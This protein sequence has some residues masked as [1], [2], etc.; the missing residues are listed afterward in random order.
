MSQHHHHELEEG[1]ELCLDYNKLQKIAAT[2]LEVIPAVAQHAE[3]GDVLIIG[4]VNQDALQVALR[5]RRVVFWSTSRNTLWIKGAGSGDSLELIETLVN[6]EQNSILYRCLPLGKGA[7]HTKDAEGNPRAS[8]FY[9]RIDDQ[10]ALE[11][12]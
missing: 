3:T 12:V 6:C 1:T 4:Y 11:M 9:R 10:G 7:C 8:C 5:E 2:G